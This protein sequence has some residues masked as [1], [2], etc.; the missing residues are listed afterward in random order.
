GASS[1]FPLL[2]LLGSIGGFVDAHV[3]IAPYVGVHGYFARD[4]Q[5]S[6]ALRRTLFAGEAEP[7]RVG[8]F[9]ED[10]D[11]IHGVA[12]L[13]KNLKQLA[14]KSQFH[15]LRFI[16]CANTGQGDTVRL[17]PIATLPIPLVEGRLLGVPS[18][19]DV[20]DH[21]AAERYDLLHV[22]APG[23]LGLAALIAGS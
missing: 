22:V 1:G 18:L 10:M 23:P 7:L 17:R 6:R 20:M 5:K 21:V 9:V 12:T 11:E 8:I 15:H 3:F 13:Y 2:S 14:G 16:Q 4:I 19:L